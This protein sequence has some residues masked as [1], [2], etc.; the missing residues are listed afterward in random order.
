VG[1]AATQAQVEAVGEPHL[2]CSARALDQ[3]APDVAVRSAI[4]EA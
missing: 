3:V 1:E 2:W 4:F